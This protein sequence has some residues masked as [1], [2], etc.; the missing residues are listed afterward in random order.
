MQFDEDDYELECNDHFWDHFYEKYS[1][2]ELCSF[3]TK[4][5]HFMFT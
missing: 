5:M 2:I 1:T 4:R 3:C